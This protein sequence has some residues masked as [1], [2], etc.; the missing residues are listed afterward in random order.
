MR[1]RRIV[2]VVELC[3]GLVVL[4]G[5]CAKVDSGKTG[6][7][8]GAGGC[9]PSMLVEKERG[10]WPRVFGQM[11]KGSDGDR[12][13]CPACM[14]GKPVHICASGENLMLGGLG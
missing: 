7:V 2:S 1:A 9:G 4:W 8:S 10:V 14:C 12:G 11:C 13:E 3:G 6:G 5:K